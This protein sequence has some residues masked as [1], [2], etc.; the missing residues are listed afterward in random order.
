M[1]K[2]PYS[3]NVSWADTNSYG[4]HRFAIIMRQ[5][6]AYAYQLLDFNAHKASSAREVQ[7]VWNAKNEE[8][9]TNFTVERSVDGGETFA[10]LGGVPA[11]GAGNYALSDKNPATA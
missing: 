11:T 3:F 2:G 5:Y 8:N 9:Y 6:P 10:A 4:A 1:R 7:V